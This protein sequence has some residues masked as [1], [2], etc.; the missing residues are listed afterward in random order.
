MCA[1]NSASSPGSPTGGET[2]A[3]FTPEELERLARACE[4][5]PKV[6]LERHQLVR[7]PL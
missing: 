7:G 6:E 4:V 5:V 3:V 2:Q 1:A